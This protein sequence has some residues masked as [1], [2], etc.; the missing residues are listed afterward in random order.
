[1][2]AAVGPFACFAR[3]KC[4]TLLLSNAETVP[5]PA[6]TLS[7][8][9]AL[10]LDAFL[11]MEAPA[12]EVLSDDLGCKILSSL[13]VPSLIRAG[14]VC[15]RW[16]RIATSKD[17]IHL[18]QKSAAQ[19]R[20]PWCLFSCTVTQ[21]EGDNEKLVDCWSYDPQFRRWYKMSVS[22]FEASHRDGPLALG[23]GHLRACSFSGQGGTGQR[24][25]PCYWVGNPLT[26]K[27][28]LIA[29][30]EGANPHGGG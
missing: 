3:S 2:I 23:V 24:Q 8:S 29:L 1:M 21:K 12:E 10:V 26:N 13:P 14:C 9:I 30:S 18:V 5:I 28:H 27:W 11:R 15:K 4:S 17:L 16:N 7:T 19:Q 22:G 25:G 6:S 20:R